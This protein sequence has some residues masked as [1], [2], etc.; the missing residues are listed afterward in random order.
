LLPEGDPDIKDDLE[1]DDV[2]PTFF[3]ELD[4]ISVTNLDKKC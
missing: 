3:S 2:N 1:D 4:G